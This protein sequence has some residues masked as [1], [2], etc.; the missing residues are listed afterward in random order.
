[1]TATAPV[2]PGG[3][4]NADAVAAAGL[5]VVCLDT[6]CILD[7]VRSPVRD[8][9]GFNERRE[10][11]ELVRLVETGSV[12][13]LVAEQVLAEFG[14]NLSLVETEAECAVRAHADRIH[15]VDALVGLTGPTVT[16]GVAHL[17]EHVART[18][19]WA[20]RLV[21]ASWVVAPDAGVLPR[22]FAR[23]MQ[24]RTPARRGKD[25]M[26]DC[27]VIETYLAAVAGLRHLGL[28]SPVVFASSNVR[29][30]GERGTFRPDLEGEAAAVDLRYMPNLA[31]ARNAVG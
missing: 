26:K 27:V 21:Q 31:A 20:E 28:A 25:S 24:A 2:A 4:F 22:A 15:A 8:D 16:T 18:R 10:A 12:V 6:C 29:D 13:S 1:M 3:R 5:P 7:V 17:A 23:V 30:Y 14:D 9:V 19:A 11:L